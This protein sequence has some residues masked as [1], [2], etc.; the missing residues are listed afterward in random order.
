MKRF[1]ATIIFLHILVSLNVHTVSA[2]TWY[3][4]NVASH[5]Y[6]QGVDTNAGTSAGVAVLSINKAMALASVGDT[7]L[8]NPTATPYQENSGSYYL[9]ITKTL[10]IATDPAYVTSAGKAIIQGTTASSPS[11]TINIAANNVVLQNFKIDGGNQSS[12]L[13]P[14]VLQ[15]YTGIQ[16][17]S[18]DIINLY[19]SGYG[20]KTNA[21]GVSATLDKCSQTASN[22]N[23]ASSIFVVFTASNCTINILGCNIS[24]INRVAVTSGTQTGISLSVGKSSDGTRNIFS[25]LSYGF[26]FSNA[27]TFTSISIQSADF[28]AINNTAITDMSDASVTVSAITVKFCS[29]AGTGA[30]ISLMACTCPSGDVSYNT[31]SLPGYFIL[32]KSIRVSSINIHDNSIT[33]SSA[34]NEPIMIAQGGSGLKVYNNTISTDITAHVIEMGSDGVI[35][36]VANTATSTA[37]ISLGDTS[38]HNYFSQPFT[39]V[40]S[41]SGLGTTQLFAAFRMMVKKVGSPMGTVTGYLYSDNSGSPGSLLSTSEYALQASNLPTSSTWVEWWFPSKATTSYV[42]QYWLVLKYTG[43]NDST[44]YVSIAAE[45]TYASKAKQSSDGAAWGS[46]LSYASLFYACWGAYE[47]LQPQVYNNKITCTNSATPHCILVG[48]CVGALVY[49]NQI[50]GGGIPLIYKLVDG[51]NVTYP[52]I[53][54]NNVVWDNVGSQQGFRDKGSRSTQFYH[55]TIVE[56]SVLEVCVTL[57]GDSE[58]YITPQF[59]CQGSQNPIVKNNILYRISTSGS[60]P[61]YQIGSLSSN[62]TQYTGTCV[63]PVISNNC[64]YVGSYTTAGIDNRTSTIGTAYTTFSQWQGAGFDVNSISTD[65]LLKNESTPSSINDFIPSMRSYCVGIGTNL[66]SIVTY[67]L[68]GNTRNTSPTVGALSVPSRSYNYVRSLIR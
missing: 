60:S 48:G 15:S 13:Q 3:V 57:D 43:T 41:N 64:V 53:C 31:S 36:P 47:M 17:I 34:T 62:V 51:T 52:S 8:V 9:S 61:V 46:S 12:N 19:A 40:A 49:N 39:A 42:T 1:F 23:A 27:S 7:I 30:G 44:N 56:T 28:S 18:C 50:Y 14:V 45:S 6:A 24:G 21:T 26:Q 63:N 38:A 2:A 16:I 35:Y 5:G 68:L 25:S 58:T 10:T 66:T 67:D 32:L 4:S 59:N 22:G 65:P 54:Y 11:R 37:A 33:Q 29:F 55:N 20:V